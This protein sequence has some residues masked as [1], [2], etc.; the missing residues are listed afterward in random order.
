MKKLLKT[1]LA[2]AISLVTLVGCDFSRPSNGDVKLVSMKTSL[3]EPSREQ[4]KAQIKKANES[5]TSSEEN[6][7][8]DYQYVLLDMSETDFYVT[9][10]LSNPKDYHILD[11]NLTCDDKDLKLYVE[12]SPTLLTSLKSINWLGDTNTSYTLHFQSTSDKFLSTLRIKKMLYIDRDNARVKYNADVSTNNEVSIYKVTNTTL[13]NVYFKENKI[14]FT[15]NSTDEHISNIKLNGNEVALNKETFI[16]LE[17]NKPYLWTNNNDINLNLTYTINVGELSLEKA[18]Q[19]SL[20]ISDY[21]IFMINKGIFRFY[22]NKQFN[23]EKVEVYNKEGV[24]LEPTRIENEVNDD[25]N[26][27]AYWFS[28]K[29]NIGFV[30]VYTKE[31]VYTI[32]PLDYQTEETS[33]V[34]NKIN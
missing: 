30:K 14:Y 32:T 11:F 2:T 23:W 29:E 9:I 8:V 34:I 7:K 18:K 20:T 22:A 15:I 24:L 16:E 3:V 21:V 10:N 13:D 26:Y 17:E 12:N 19:Y 25:E 27:W 4:P 33:F 1:I 6:E 31:Y 5:E 28:K